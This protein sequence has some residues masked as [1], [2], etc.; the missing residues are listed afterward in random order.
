[1]QNTGNI[2]TIPQALQS[3]QGWAELFELKRT[4]QPHVHQIEPTNHCPYHCIMCPRSKKMTRELGFMD[5]ELFKQVVD[6]IATYEPVVRNK[7]TELFHFGESLLHPQLPE[8]V[9]YG[10]EKD[11]KL[12]LSVN[13][14]QL[15]SALSQELLSTGV[16]EIIISLDGY[17]EKSYREIRGPAANYKNAVNNIETVLR[18]SQASQSPTRI[19]VRMILLDRNQEKSASFRKY[20]QQKGA[21]VETRTFFPWTEPEMTVLGDYDRYPSHMVCPF[22][23]QYLVVQ[24]DGSVVPCCRD[25]NGEH[26]MGSVQHTSLQEIWKGEK[27][28]EFRLQHGSGDLENM[29]ICK[30]CMGIYSKQ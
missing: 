6:E 18:L 26:R 12:I 13:G 27:F 1:M 8:M 22:P 9:R 15:T 16:D 24:W 23:F 5:M 4:R 21:N 14:P 25:Y 11:L 17:D 28:A 10:K 30:R 19:T 20:W 2:Q 29:G 7:P 3:S